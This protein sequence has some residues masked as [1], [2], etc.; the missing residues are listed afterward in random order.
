MLVTAVLPAMLAT[1]CATAGDAGPAPIVVVRHTEAALHEPVWSPGTHALLALTDDG[2]VA[3][4]GP[5]APGTLLSPPLGR[6]GENVVTDPD[7]P[8]VAFV[9]RPDAG[10]VVALDTRDLH[11]VGTLPLGA[12][13]D[14]LAT[15]EGSHVLLAL[16]E[17]RTTVSGIDLDDRRAL[18][19]QEVH[20]SA[21]AE[22]DGPARGRPVA[23]HVLGSDG[24][25]HYKGA[26]G[27]VEE[28]G[29]I[30][31]RA[32]HGAGDRV[33]VDRIYVAERDS[34]RL[35]AVETPPDHEGLSVVA[36]ADLE[37]PVRDVGTD[38]TR[39]Y[40]ATDDALVVFATDSFIGYPDGHLHRIATI[41][42]RDA[43]PDGPARSAS[44][45]G[46]AVGAD[47]VWL[48]FDG[49]DALVGIARPPIPEP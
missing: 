38:E 45:S 20:A 31:V 46:L 21:D 30:D 6:V 41:P 29:H 36:T 16:S 26:P 27:E 8:T 48:T 37:S 43:L 44:V 11:P 10:Q 3:R 12:A 24:I 34:D 17:D 4:V 49:Q 5:G 7:D 35:L 1:A 14:Y 23:Y 33:K 40:A 15:D 32:S 42:Y 25:T 47:R 22:L 28:K 2:R 39:V 19:P 9:A 13:P 18:P